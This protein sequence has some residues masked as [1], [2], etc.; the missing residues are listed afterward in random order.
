MSNRPR[1]TTY[2]LGNSLTS[3]SSL[4]TLPPSPVRVFRPTRS[5]E[6]PGAAAKRPTDI[7][8]DPLNMA[9]TT[10]SSD[11]PM[12]VGISLP[13]VPSPRP[14]YTVGSAPSRPLTPKHRSLSGDV[15][16]RVPS[17]LNPAS[18]LQKPAIRTRDVIFDLNAGPLPRPQPNQLFTALLAVSPPDRTPTSLELP[19]TPKLER[20]SPRL[21][22]D[23]RSS[24]P[25]KIS[26]SR[27]DGPARRVTEP[28]LRSGEDAEEVDVL[29][30]APN[31]YSTFVAT[32][33][34]LK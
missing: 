20:C 13:S 10:R 25:R 26:P 24:A 18:Q 2:S 29:A 11:S 12:E 5:A 23:K 22:N 17:P 33:A 9:S 31:S 3:I 4:M 27:P 34:S 30:K 14:K 28:V 16:L 8:V 19:P 7:W 6:M 32:I 1:P 15:R 21:T